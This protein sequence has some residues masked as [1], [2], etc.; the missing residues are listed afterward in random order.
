MK[1]Y[2][3]LA[4][5]FL[6][7]GCAYSIHQYAATDF[8]GMK[9]GTRVVGEGSKQYILIKTDNQFVEK[10]YASLLSKCPSGRISGITS[11]YRTDLSFL[12]FTER[13][14]LEGT[15]INE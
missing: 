9:Q 13:L 4:A 1:F 6:S 12:S 8:T 3:A 11:H 2:F 7:T 10:A 15:C 14:I 5:A